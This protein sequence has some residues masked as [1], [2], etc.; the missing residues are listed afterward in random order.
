[1]TRVAALIELLK[2][3]TYRDNDT[4][5][6]EDY[7][8]IKKFPSLDELTGDYTQI[9]YRK[10]VNLL[11]AKTIDVVTHF[12]DSMISNCHPGSMKLFSYSMLM[13][14]LSRLTRKTQGYFKI[15]T[16]PG[17]VNDSFKIKVLIPE[18]NVCR[19]YKW[20]PSFFVQL[21]QAEYELDS[22]NYSNENTSESLNLIPL[23]TQPGVN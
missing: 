3:R 9:E 17:V 19:Y 16:S 7:K 18:G 12:I 11:F 2:S 13:T 20:E 10:M 22:D 23:T 4:E 1:M 15:E 6:I 21:K 8:M 5:W 14:F